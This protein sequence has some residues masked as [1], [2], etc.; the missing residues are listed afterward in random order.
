MTFWTSFNTEA[1]WDHVF[2]EIHTVGQNNW[3]TLPDA[4][5]HTTQSTGS[6][7]PQ[8]TSGGWRTLHPWLDHY[9]TQV[10][11]TVVPTGRPAC[12]TPRPATPTAGSS[13]GSTSRAYAGQQ[14]EVSISYASDWA[15]RAWASSWTT[16]S[17]RTGRRP[18]RRV[19]TADDAG[20]AR[21][22]RSECERLH[23]DRLH[24]VPG[25]CSRSHARHD[26]H[27]LRLR[28]HQR[29]R[30]AQRRHAP[31]DG[32]PPAALG[33]RASTFDREGGPQGP[34]SLV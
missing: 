32:L 28:G 7:C 3:T 18:S 34:P 4:N 29:C 6:P 2:V 11:T 13:G 25:G 14:V 10:G 15:V 8:D 27:G 20:P 21:R 17:C 26:L 23:S 19:S 30:G 22:K 9:Q 16:S 5:G 1:D 24:R 12:G 31:C 33:S